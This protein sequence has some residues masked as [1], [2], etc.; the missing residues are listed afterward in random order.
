MRPL[1]VT[2]LVT[3]GIAMSVPATASPTVSGDTHARPAQ[4]PAVQ[5]TQWDPNLYNPRDRASGWAR[6]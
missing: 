4:G 5:Y 2:V 3:A 1:T 6:L